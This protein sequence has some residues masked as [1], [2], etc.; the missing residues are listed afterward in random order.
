MPNVY[1]DEYPSVWVMTWMKKT[2][3]CDS[4]AICLLLYMTSFITVQFLVRRAKE[5]N[6]EFHM[7]QR[8]AWIPLAHIIGV[9]CYNSPTVAT[10]VILW[11][12]TLLFIAAQVMT[13]LPNLREKFFKFAMAG[14]LGT[15][16]INAIIHWA[17]RVSYN[18]FSI[19]NPN[20]FNN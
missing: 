16:L 19:E 8:K 5:P 6:R 2:G 4:V 9:Y 15:V 18:P 20:Q 3:N 14:A 12:V 13:I 7:V 17:V 1:S 11:F 10:T